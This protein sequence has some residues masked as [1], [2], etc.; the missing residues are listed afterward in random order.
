MGDNDIL[1]GGQT[2]GCNTE[3]IETSIDVSNFLQKDQYL[4]EFSDSAT[5]PDGTTFNEKAK[6]RTNLDIYSRS[7]VEEMIDTEHDHILQTV[8]STMRK[9]LEMEDPHGSNSYTDEVIQQ[10]SL[11]IGTQLSTLKA[12]LESLI[13]KRLLEFVKTNDFETFKSKVLKDTAL[14]FENIYTKA[15]VYNKDEI[16]V[17]N[18]QFVKTDGTT[19]FIKPQE[20]IDPKLDRHL[21][22][23]RYVDNIFQHATDFLNN[24][25]FRSWINQRL[26]VYAKLSDTYSR[27]I[28][29][30]KLQNLVDSVVDTAVNKAL[31]DILTSHLEI[32]DPHGDRAYAD[33]TFAT[34]EN[35]SELIEGL[36]NDREEAIESI[37]KSEVVWKTS[38]PVQ[39]T[40]GFVEDNTD[41]NG[42]KFTLQGIMDAIFYGKKV[43]IST[44]QQE[45]AIGDTTDVIISIHGSTE[46]VKSIIIKQ[47][48]EILAELE[49]SDLDDKGQ[50][51]VKSLPIMQDSEFTVEVTYY[52]IEE[53][54]SASTIVK[55]GYK[56]FIGIIPQFETAST[57]NWDRLIE[58]S[59]SDP[60]NNQFFD[61]GVDSISN[62][63]IRYNFSGDPSQIFIA[64]PANYPDII[65]MA[66]S[67]Q[68]FGIGAF[69][70]IQ[71]IPINIELSNGETKSILYK[72]FVYKQPIVTLSTKV[73]FKFN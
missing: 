41:F 34:K 66:T 71:Q 68:Q 46:T 45:V 52:G 23:K 14:A 50:A 73:T 28:I 40:V 10:Q 18:S 2:S 26:A 7:E 30:N 47:D 19:P 29:D 39:T 20:G 65:E 57:I 31:T 55:V 69:N 42:N 43:Q 72:Y 8:N 53:S 17:L 16:N 24:I 44:T 60:V 21:A 37:I 63:S 1:I 61:T 59:N 36:K 64:I 56:A 54:I 58:L 62:L 15:K 6:V 11:Q 13:N 33:S 25:E 12:N 48:N 27:D 35:V 51:K 70:V 5:L 38:G 4:G 9:H 32:Q 3:A 22:T 49:A 67:S